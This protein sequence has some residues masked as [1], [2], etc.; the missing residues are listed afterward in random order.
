MCGRYLMTSSPSLV[1]DCFD[2]RSE[3]SIIATYNAAPTQCLPV[4]REGVDG[5][6]CGLLRWGLIPSWAKDSSI[7]NRMINARSETAAEKPSFREAIRSRRCLVV[8]DGFYEWK[9][10]GDRKR[11]YCFRM[12]DGLPFGMAGLWDRWSSP[13]GKMVESFTI[14]TTGPNPMVGEVHDR[15][16]VIIDREQYSRWLALDLTEPGQIACLL[17][18]YPAEL[19]DSHEVSDHVNSPRNNDPRCIEPI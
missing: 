15:M 8:A 3:P 4:V 10:E 6:S 11:A 12:G 13:E 2:L 18:S 16:P 5:K 9:R 19:M 17:G 7:G 14:L 1:Q